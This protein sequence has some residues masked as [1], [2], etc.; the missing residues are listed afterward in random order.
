MTTAGGADTSIPAVDQDF[1]AAEGAV[2]VNQ[3]DLEEFLTAAL[4]LGRSQ[5]E[6]GSA[7]REIIDAIPTAPDGSGPVE[8][9]LPLPI[10]LQNVAMTS[11]QPGIGEVV[12]NWNLSGAQE[13]VSD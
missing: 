3:A 1:Q 9:S 11:G 10:E 12:F 6:E 13:L 8:P 5:F 2:H 4:E 7:E